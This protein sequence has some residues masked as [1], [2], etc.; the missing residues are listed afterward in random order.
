MREFYVFN[1]R[2]KNGKMETEPKIH[3]GNPPA[4]GTVINI[5]IDDETV[6]A[7]I[8]APHVPRG[9]DGEDAVIDVYAD[10]I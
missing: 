3:E 6:P 8:S 10:E 9:R 7:R 1:V 2:R 4:V 5:I